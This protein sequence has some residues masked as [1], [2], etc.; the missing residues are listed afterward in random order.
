MDI[1]GVLPPVDITGMVP[2]TVTTG[3]VGIKN[4]TI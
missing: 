3:F 2:E 1:T 4:G